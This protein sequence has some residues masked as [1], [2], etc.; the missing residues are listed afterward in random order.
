MGVGWILR[1][2]TREKPMLPC[3]Q[4]RSWGSLS[5]ANLFQPGHRWALQGLRA[6]P[7]SLSTP[8]APFCASCR[9]TGLGTQ[10]QHVAGP[11]TWHEGE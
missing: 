1:G 9:K 5:R 11:I 7:P 3:G 2:G 4:V 8:P 6:F 10:S